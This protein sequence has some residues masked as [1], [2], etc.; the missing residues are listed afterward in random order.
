MLPSQTLTA[1][2]L[3]PDARCGVEGCLRS[4]GSP[5]RPQSCLTHG[6]ILGSTQHREHFLSLNRM[7]FQFKGT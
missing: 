1:L 5:G 2:V 7:Q 3:A 6:D 4:P